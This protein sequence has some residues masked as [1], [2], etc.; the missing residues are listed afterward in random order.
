[1][2][3]E[4]KNKMKNSISQSIN[5]KEIKIILI[6]ALFTVIIWQIPFGN[7]ILYPFTILGTWF[8]EM[9]H[10]LTALIIG[11]N[12]HKLEIFANGSGIAYWSGNVF[13]ANLGAAA[14]AFGG[15]I[16]PT[17]AGAIFLTASKNTRFTKFF[18]LLLSIFMILSIII[19]IR[20]IIGAIIILTIALI[21]M[22]IAIKSGNLFSKYTLQ[23]LA[24]QAFAS[25]YQSIDYLFS[26]GGSIGSTNYYSDTYH[27]QE[28]LLLPYWFWAGVII[29]FSILLIYISIRN[30]SKKSTSS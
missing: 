14:V 9:G 19:W 30:I 26:S 16:G 12:F 23:F 17:I 6:F 5:N 27:I 4:Y 22:F 29:V 8:H 15:P 20:T 2:K 11:G 1:M 25:L 7:Y 18:L 28:N 3:Q 10:G 13:G 24:V 21:I